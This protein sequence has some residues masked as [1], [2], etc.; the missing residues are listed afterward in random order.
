MPEKCIEMSS[1]FKDSMFVIYI[2]KSTG[3]HK[4]H[5]NP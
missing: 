3:T 2:Q 5:K 4:T 1:A